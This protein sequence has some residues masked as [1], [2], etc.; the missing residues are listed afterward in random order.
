MDHCLQHLSIA[1]N[2]TIYGLCL[3]CF[4]MA[5]PNSIAGKPASQQFGYS[6][7]IFGPLS[8]SISAPYGHGSISLGIG[9]LWLCGSLARSLALYGYVTLS[10][11][12]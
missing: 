3:F 11:G 6:L 9:P 8:R 12:L 2:V 10:L 1:T 7:V 4:T 5:S